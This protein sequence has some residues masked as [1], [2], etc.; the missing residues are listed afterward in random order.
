MVD[1]DDLPVIAPDALARAEA[2]LAALA[3]GYLGWAS[4]DF[5]RLVASLDALRAGAPGQLE[6]L[7]RIAHDMK[8]QAGTFGYPLITHVA[9][10][11]CRLIEHAPGDFPLMEAHVDAIG[12]I[13]DRK[14]DGE[15]GED[16]RRI[17]RSLGC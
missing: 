8:G 12:Q 5:Q 14:L 10:S 2:A 7:F 9:N 15:C 1:D 3:E 11:L 13:I 4:A 16:G 6:P 17:L